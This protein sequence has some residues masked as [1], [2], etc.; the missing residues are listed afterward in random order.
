MCTKYNLWFHV[1][2]A[3]GALAKVLPEYETLMAGI[4]DCDSIAFDLHK[5]MYMPYEIG[6]ILIKEARA[7]KSS[8]AYTP[9][10]LM[11]HERGFSAGPETLGNYGI[12][13]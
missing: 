9:D 1:D 13:W 8:F 3:F 2:G 6:C 10:Y 12:E 5:W 7:Q 11:K 4:A